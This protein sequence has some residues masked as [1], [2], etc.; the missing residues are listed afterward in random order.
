MGGRIRIMRNNKLD[1][2]KQLYYKYSRNLVI[3]VI[4]VF[5]FFVIM[6]IWMVDANSALSYCAK[7][8]YN[9]SCMNA[10]VYDGGVVRFI[11]YAPILSISFFA[12]LIS[13]IKAFSARKKLGSDFAKIHKITEKS[14][15]RI[16][17]K[18]YHDD[19]L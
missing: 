3:F 7:Q 18:E 12:L 8:D 17:K 10:Y 9:G 11:C 1:K 2:K 4:S 19:M 16:R 14:A 15:R 5:L 6:F 13:G